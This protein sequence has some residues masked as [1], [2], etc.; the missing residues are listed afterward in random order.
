MRKLMMHSLEIVF[1]QHINIDIF[2][3]DIVYII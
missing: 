3:I 2:R 1:I